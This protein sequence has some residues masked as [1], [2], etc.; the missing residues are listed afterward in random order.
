MKEKDGKEGRIHFDSTLKEEMITILGDGDD[1]CLGF[2][3]GFLSSIHKV[4]GIL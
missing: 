2:I 4:A 1:D 3:V